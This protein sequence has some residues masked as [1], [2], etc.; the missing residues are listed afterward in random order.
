MRNFPTERGFV[1]GVLKSF[2]GLSSSIFTSI[3]AW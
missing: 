2:L 3:Y 1:V